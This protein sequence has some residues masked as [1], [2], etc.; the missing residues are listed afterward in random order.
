MTRALSALAANL[1]PLGILIVAGGL[2]ARFG[3][4]VAFVGIGLALVEMGL[5]RLAGEA[6]LLWSQPAAGSE[7]SA[8]DNA[9]G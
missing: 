6:V 2:A 5:E 4:W 9:T 1:I 3:L 8:P 7:G